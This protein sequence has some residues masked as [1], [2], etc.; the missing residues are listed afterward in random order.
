MKK[1]TMRILCAVLAALML[2]PVPVQA[3]KKETLKTKILETADAMEETAGSR[4]KYLLADEELLPA[5]SS[6]SDWTAIS[7]A[8]AGKE[9]AYGD[10]LERLEAYV[11][12]EYKKNGV[13]D[14]FKATEYHR[15]ALTVLALGG[16]PTAFGRDEAGEPVNLIA[17][18][19][20]QF[21]G[22]TPGQQGS[23]GLA[24]A[25]L[26]LD[27]MA[28]EVP[29]DA[30]FTRE[31]L[32]EELCAS[33]TE[34]GGFA[35]SGGSDGDIDITAMALQALAPY[36]EDEK[37]AE[38][39]EQALTWLSAQM[40]EE[41]TFFAYD[42]ASAESSAQVILALCA[43]GRDP[44]EENSFVKAGG[45][46]LDG[47]EQFRLEN[48]MYV[49]T[50]SDGEADMLASEQALLALEAVERLRTEGTSL[51]DL[52][53]YTMDENLKAGEGKSFLPVIVVGVVAVAAAAGT[54]L[55]RK[56]KKT[57]KNQESKQHV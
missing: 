3:A 49:H 39:I 47:L 2:L 14:S 56:Q 44:E 15:V 48:G 33:Q 23:N 37:I 25:L 27:A 38:V 55:V 31:Q 42:M 40:T 7:F 45:S 51:W 21:H 17:D 11:T 9:N 54:L 18:G 53:A 28:Y 30:K 32:V 29:A 50:L 35:L 46:L 52:Q 34:S 1:K 6:L 16:D 57:K 26:A 12:E 36:Q 4:E 43:L 41:A 22:E 5:G 24:Y 20:Y 19:V 10:Y 8:F 13:L